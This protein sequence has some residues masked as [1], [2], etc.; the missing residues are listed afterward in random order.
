MNKGLETGHAMAELA[1]DR[2]GFD[3]K[4]LALEAVRQHALKKRYFTTEQVRGANPDLPEPPDKRAWGAI[5]RLAKKEG[6]T[7]PH[8]WIATRSMNGCDA[9]GVKD[10]RGRKHRRNYTHTGTHMTEYNFMAQKNKPEW[11][12]DIKMAQ[13]RTTQKMSGVYVSGE[14]LPTRVGSDDH[15]AHPSRAGNTLIYKDGR[16]ETIK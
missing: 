9:L 12:E 14:L 15:E 10:L 2:A 8:N 5:A 6:F 13:I 16:R 4:L 11:K 1:A 3:W 7:Q